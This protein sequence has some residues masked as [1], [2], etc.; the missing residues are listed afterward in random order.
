MIKL[1]NSKMIDAET[2]QQSLNLALSN[3]NI[4]SEAF[5]PAVENI[6]LIDDPFSR[7]PAKNILEQTFH[8]RGSGSRMSAQKAD[9]I[10][11]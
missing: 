1:N 5:T 9:N 6:V 8:K 11:T 2:L 4:N 7:L 10:N 3:D